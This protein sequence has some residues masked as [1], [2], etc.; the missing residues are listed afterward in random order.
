IRVVTEPLPS[1][2][3]AAVGIWIGSGSRDESDEQAGLAHFLEHLLFKG[4]RSYSALEIAEVFDTFGG[5]LNA[6]TARDYTLV[7][8]RVLD[9]HLPKALD[10]MTDMVFTPTFTDI[11]AE[12]EVVLEEIAMVEDTPQELV[13]DLLTETVF[14]DHPLGRPVLGSADVISSVS[15]RSIAAYHRGRYTGENVVVAAAGSVE[16]ERLVELI[17]EMAAKLPPRPARRA[18]ARAPFIAPPLPGIRFQ[19]KETEQYH[20]CVGAPG[21]ARSDRRRFTAS[22]LDGVLGGSA[23]SRLFQEIREKRGLAYSVYTFASQYAD[24]GQIGVYVGTREENLDACL[25]IVGD[26]FDAVAAGNF[27]RDELERAKE[28]LKGRVML[29]ME[30][31]SNRMS[32]LGKS[33]VTDSELLSL[34]RILAEIEAVDAEAVAQLAAVLLER[35]R[36][37]VAAVG[38]NEDRVLTAVGRIAPSL[39]GRAAPAA[40]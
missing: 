25:E 30:A 32:R 17:S 40:A 19:A 4:S 24:T 15:R 39:V 38:P 6:S 18:S 31:T 34:D 11:D 27:R 3:S 10:V 12:R 16:H 37:S 9:E 28:N 8:A 23:S 13:H 26:E 1:V 5:E 22:I 7:Y 35:A 21:I 33:L 2:R 36:L 14:G 20:V 29:S